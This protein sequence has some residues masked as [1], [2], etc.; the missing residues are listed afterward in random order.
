[1]NAASQ[2]KRRLKVVGFAS[3]DVM[4]RSIFLS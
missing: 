1:M 2:M 4:L 3:L